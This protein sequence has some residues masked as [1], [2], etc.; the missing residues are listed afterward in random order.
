MKT[1]RKAMKFYITKLT[2]KL[3]RYPPTTIPTIFNDALSRLK[4][5]PTPPRLKTGRYVEYLK[6]I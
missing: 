2:E 1:A 6:T 3:S 4:H 5:N